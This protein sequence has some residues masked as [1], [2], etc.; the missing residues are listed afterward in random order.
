MN[1]L[2]DPGPR[3]SNLRR[4]VSTAQTTL[5]P[6]YSR[7]N[8]EHSLESN[9]GP[10]P[11]NDHLCVGGLT[12]EVRLNDDV[13]IADWQQ[14]GLARGQP[15]ARGSALALGTVPVAAGVV[16]D[17]PVPAIIASFDVTAQRRGAAVLDRRHDLELAE[18]QMPGVC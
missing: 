18:A 13:E 14:I 5:H 11:C 9:G 4:H 17:P 8:L 16:G 1:T 15:S 3:I 12:K 10:Q 2:E 6:A 7:G